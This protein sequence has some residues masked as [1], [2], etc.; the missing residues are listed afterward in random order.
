MSKPFILDGIGS[1]PYAFSPNE[2]RTS[3]TGRFWRAGETWA[4]PAYR[5]ERCVC[6][7]VCNTCVWLRICGPALFTHVYMCLPVCVCVCKCAHVETMRA[8][9]SACDESDPQ[10]KARQTCN[11]AAHH[12]HNVHTRKHKQTHARALSLSQPTVPM[13]PQFLTSQR[14]AAWR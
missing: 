12:T 7:C 6:V 14:E 1:K 5:R 11:P 3:L 8:C 10:P 9:P 13:E 4:C 2:Q